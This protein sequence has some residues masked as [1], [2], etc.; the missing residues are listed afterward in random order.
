MIAADLPD[1]KAHVWHA[2]ARREIQEE[3]T[4][5]QFPAVKGKIAYG[6]GVKNNGAL[7]MFSLRGQVEKLGKRG[8]FQEFVG[9][10]N[11]I[12][13]QINRVRRLVDV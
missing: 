12:L 13:I 5:R 11:G 9:C 4:A 7:G 10:L 2:P 8:A 3:D 6:T 1:V